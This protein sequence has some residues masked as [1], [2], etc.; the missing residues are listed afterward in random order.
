MVN[1]TKAALCKRYLLREQRVL[2]LAIG[3]VI[4]LTLASHWMLNGSRYPMWI[5]MRMISGFAA[6]HKVP[7]CLQEGKGCGMEIRRSFLRAPTVARK[8]QARFLNTYPVSWKEKMTKKIAPANWC[9]LPN[10]MIWK[11]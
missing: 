11:S 6:M 5:L 4:A 7:R 3:K 1:C 10:R 9:C 8:R 2:T